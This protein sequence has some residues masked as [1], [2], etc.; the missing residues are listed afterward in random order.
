MG[1][2]HI[3]QDIGEGEGWLT[4]ITPFGVDL[5]KGVAIASDGNDVMQAAYRTCRRHGCIVQAELSETEVAAFKAGAEA[6]VAMP[7]TTGQTLELNV[8][9]TGFSAAWARL[10]EF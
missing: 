8:S 9:L 3:R 7:L 6:K 1:E 4:M 2:V 10:N 5:A